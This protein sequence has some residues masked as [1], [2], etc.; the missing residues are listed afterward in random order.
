MMAS[1]TSRRPQSSNSG[2]LRRHT[3]RAAFHAF[4]TKNDRSRAYSERASFSRTIGASASRCGASKSN[5]GSINGGVRHPSLRLRPVHSTAG[6]LQSKHLHFMRDMRFFFVRCHATRDH[7][8]AP[9]GCSSCC[10]QCAAILLL[11]IPLLST[12]EQF[13]HF[14]RI[15]AVIGLP[16]YFVCSSKMVVSMHCMFEAQRLTCLLVFIHISQT[17]CFFND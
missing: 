4:H 7:C 10:R 15:C 6:W 5:R 11:T 16:D 9:A 12:S 8:F 14:L 3:S 17:V 13:P 1:A 2:N